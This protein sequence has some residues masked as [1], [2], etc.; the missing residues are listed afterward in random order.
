MKGKLL[1]VLIV[2]LLLTITFSGCFEENKNIQPPIANFTYSA[3][4]NFDSNETI[5]NTISFSDNSTEK[6]KINSWYWDFGD[7]NISYEQN[8]VH[9]FEKNGVYN[10]TLTVTNLDG[11][12]NSTIHSVFIPYILFLTYT[13]F[14]YHPNVN[15]TTEDTILFNATIHD[16][17]I[18]YSG[19]C[20]WM[21][22]HW[23]F[24]DGTGFFTKN[25]TDSGII[26]ISTGIGNETYSTVFYNSEALHKYN[27]LG[28]YT[29]KLYVTLVKDCDNIPPDSE[30]K[31]YPWEY[32]T[33]NSIIG[34]RKN[35]IV[36]K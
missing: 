26:N 22:F 13:N 28:N 35:D 34:F 5:T 2:F 36:I 19:L 24:G 20:Y 31:Y 33:N 18:F 23:D 14:D 3:Q 4:S 21:G 9:T 7:G 1:S 10:V 12:A 29:V 25:I 30:T 11:V 32:T 6:G 17:F 8:P 16:S 27:R 15:L